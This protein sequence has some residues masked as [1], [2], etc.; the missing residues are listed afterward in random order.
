MN[1]ILFDHEEMTRTRH[2]GFI[3]GDT[4]FDYMLTYSQHFFGK[5]VVTCLQSKKS[6]ILGGEDLEMLEEFADQFGL[7]LE[8]AEHLARFLEGPLSDQLLRT[9]Y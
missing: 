5:T 4:R 8:D 1:Q 7:A 9:K 3:A 6:A 2:V